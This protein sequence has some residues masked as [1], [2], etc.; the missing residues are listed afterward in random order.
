MV[1]KIYVASSWRNQLQQEVVKELRAA[2]FD[3]Y[4][5]KN[6]VEGNKGFYWSDI[7]PEWQ[8]WTPEQFRE[9]L[10][11]PI[12][13]SGFKLDM[14]ALCWC[15]ACVLVMPCGR[16]AHLEAGYTIGAGKPTAI[17]LSDGEPELM[18]RMADSICLDTGEVVSFLLQD[19]SRI[20]R[21]NGDRFGRTCETCLYS[22]AAEALEPCETCKNHSNWK[23]S[24]LY[25][26]YLKQQEMINE[27]SNELKAAGDT[28]LSCQGTMR[29]LN[30]ELER[31]KKVEET[32]KTIAAHMPECPADVLPPE[33]FS[34]D[35]ITECHGQEDIA[36]CWRRVLGVD[37]CA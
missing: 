21:V 18:Y 30:D 9:S 33:V 8:G 29:V 32:V 14:D 16:S 36:R 28:M 13:V 34:C 4:D 17:L 23:P 12:A 6:P 25:E 35:D 37:P 24:L 7:D 5:F 22:G 27:A 1:K 19:P 2:G 31:L 11:H 3:V 10:R 20:K 26:E 15:D